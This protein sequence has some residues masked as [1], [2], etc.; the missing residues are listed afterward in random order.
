M[1]REYVEKRNG[2]Y[3]LAGS[4]VSLES[5]IYEFLDGASPE[6]IVDDFP[7]LSLEQV[8]GAITFYLANRSELDA[9]LA[10]TEKSWENARKH[11]SQLPAGLRDRLERAR[12]D[13][14]VKPT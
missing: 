4:R 13:L 2:G 12:R 6:S 8:Y 5:L 7:T 11:Q 10:E 1:T 14:G 9:Y 3:F